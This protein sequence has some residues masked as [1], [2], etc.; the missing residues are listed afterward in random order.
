MTLYRKGLL[1]RRSVFWLVRLLVGALHMKHPGADMSR[2]AT[3]VDD[4]IRQYDGAENPIGVGHSNHEWK[5][6]LTS[7]GFQ[8]VSHEVH[9][10]PVRFLGVKGMVPTAAHRFL[11]RRT[12]ELW[13]TSTYENN[14]FRCVA[15]S[16]FVHW[17]H[18][19]ISNWFAALLA[20]YL[21]PLLL[22][23]EL[24]ELET[25]KCPCQ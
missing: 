12:L 25:S 16:P 9:F 19:L 18:Q 20:T 24:S 3:T 10:F 7:V 1:H 5:R 11:D 15:P 13:C 8:Y 2:N 6:L 17:N 22:G 21:R 4:F 23:S 14:L